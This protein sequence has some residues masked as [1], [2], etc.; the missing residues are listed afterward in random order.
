MTPGQK[1]AAER[2]KQPFL[3]LGFDLREELYKM[4]C[5]ET[6]RPNLDLRRLPK[7]T[8]RHSQYSG[9]G[10]R[11]YLVS[12]R[13]I[14]TLGYDVTPARLLELLLHELVHHACPRKTHHGFLFIYRLNRAAEELWGIFIEDVY[15]VERGSNRV[16]AYAVDAL[17][18]EQ[19]ALQFA[20]PIARAI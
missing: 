5:T 3:V 13:I 15:T 7:L 19:L 12:N 20:N 11:A 10:G 9:S 14:L 2:R 6:L 18:T 17:I 4:A 16:K 8:I 1:I